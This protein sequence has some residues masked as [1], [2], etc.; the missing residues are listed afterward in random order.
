MNSVNLHIL[1]VFIS[2]VFSHEIDL[3]S[4]LSTL[5]KNSFHIKLFQNLLSFLKKKHINFYYL[6]FVS[7]KRA[8]I[9]E[10]NI[11]NGARRDQHA[12]RDDWSFKRSSSL[13]KHVEIACKH[14]PEMVHSL[15]ETINYR[16]TLGHHGKSCYP[17]IQ[18]SCG[19]RDF[20]PLSQG[21]RGNNDGVDIT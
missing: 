21:G 9:W 4:L 18:L 14:V 1:Y 13:L 19:T 20:P 5:S 15:R 7:K 12:N 3:H 16:N 2:H 6:L 8:T 10:E 17:S 11:G